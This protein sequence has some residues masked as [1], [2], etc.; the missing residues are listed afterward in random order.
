MNG[1][2]GCIWCLWIPL[3]LMCVSVCVCF[4]VYVCILPCPLLQTAFGSRTS[5]LLCFNWFGSS[6]AMVVDYNLIIFFYIPAAALIQKE[7]FL[8][9]F[10]FFFFFFKKPVFR[11]FSFVGQNSHSRAIA[12]IL[13]CS[14]WQ[15][16]VCSAYLCTKQPPGKLPWHDCWGEKW[17]ESGGCGGA[18]VV[19]V[20]GY[21]EFDNES[22]TASS[23]DLVVCSII[24]MAHHF[25]L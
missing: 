14:N 16:S 24:T 18:G 9:P 13:L 15:Y 5:I 10:W 22:D 11:C 1:L 7:S 12:H 21:N 19:F 25:L 2:F 6:P 4:S 8:C 20:F 17:H 23:L 3:I